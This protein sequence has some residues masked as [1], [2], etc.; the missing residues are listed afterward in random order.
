MA[1]GWDAV[2][3]DAGTVRYEMGVVEGQYK[4]TKNRRS[5]RTVEL[6]EPAIEALKRQYKLTGERESIKVNMTDRDN[7]TIRQ[8]SFRPVW[9]NS[10]TGDPFVHIKIFRESWWVRHLEAAEV[11]Y[12]GPSQCRHTFISQ[13]LTLGIPI[14]WI[15][16]QVGHSS[17]AM[18][19]RDY[20]KFIKENQPVSFAA[21][22]NQQLGFSAIGGDD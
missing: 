16:S 9:V 19:H 13:M 10:Y 22:A 3:L 4:A 5:K 7:R 2:D 17:E 8:V 15:I 21:L 11:R 18:I 20:G 6:L 1:M 14:N 12:R